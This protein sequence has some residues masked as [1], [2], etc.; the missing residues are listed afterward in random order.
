MALGNTFGHGTHV[1]SSFG[2]RT[3]GIAKDATLV[4][5]RAVCGTGK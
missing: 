2:A 3:V 4:R 5:M 1:A